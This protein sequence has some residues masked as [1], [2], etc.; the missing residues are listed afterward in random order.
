MNKNFFPNRGNKLMA[1]KAE[2]A[3]RR[4]HIYMQDW[5]N[6]LEDEEKDYLIR[7]CMCKGTCWGDAGFSLCGGQ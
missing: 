5:K 6:R 2:L 3:D 1:I 4:Q 7:E